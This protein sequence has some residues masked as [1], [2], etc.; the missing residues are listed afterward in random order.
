MVSEKMVVAVRGNDDLLVRIDPTRHDELVAVPGPSPAEMG[1][2]RAMGP[3]WVD[4]SATALSDGELTFWIG[5]AMENHTQTI[6][7][8][9]EFSG[10]RRARN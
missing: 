9:N 7:I 8:E 6:S 2:G 4:V 1:I 10:F 3:N 5:V